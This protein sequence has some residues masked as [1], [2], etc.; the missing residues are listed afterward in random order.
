[1][2]LL[3]LLSVVGVALSLPQQKLTQA[4]SVITSGYA[5]Q[6]GTYSLDGFELTRTGTVEVDPNLTW[7]QQSGSSWYALHEVGDFQGVPGG[8]ISRWQN[9][10]AGSPMRMEH[11]SILP[12]PAHLLIDT[13]HNLAFTAIYG[14][15]AVSVIQMSADGLLESVVQTLT[16]GEGC[17]DASH[18]HEIVRL[19]DIVWVVDLG[20][21][22]VY[23]YK[24]EGNQLQYVG[25]AELE[26]GA[27]PRHMVV[28][29]DKNLVYLLCELKNFLLVFSYD[30]AGSLQQLEQV[31]FANVDGQAG[32]EIMLSADKKHVYA[33]SRGDGIISVYNV[34]GNS[35]AKIQ[36][37]QLAGTWPR[38]FDIAGAVM[39]VAD[40][41]GDSVQI[42]SIDETSGMLTEGG[43]IDTT[44]A[45]AFVKIFY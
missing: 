3:L 15:G 31:E 43:T 12:Y 6:I 28:N 2:K 37:V 26:A 44:A 39:L 32:G 11:V 19:G 29:E 45:P 8:A 22:A 5:S 4:A 9:D 13:D 1:M 30:E 7:L 35:L 33:S 14:S 23:N 17:R 25:K 18:P 42:L 34:D 38:S 36:E 10:A 20:C 16:Y 24:I 21:D 40:K 27:G 41:N